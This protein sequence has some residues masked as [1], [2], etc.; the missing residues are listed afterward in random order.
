M[1]PRSQVLRKLLVA[2]VIAVPVALVSAFL[3]GMLLTPV[4][5][6]LEP[7]LGMELAG[8]SGPC[9][10]IL[11]TLFALFTIVILAIAL[12]VLF[13]ENKGTAPA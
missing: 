11:W 1:R 4:L 5:W 10:W 13:R 9:D 6:K 8:H 12:R 3:T 2:I 7:V